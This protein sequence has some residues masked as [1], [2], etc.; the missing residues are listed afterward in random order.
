MKLWANWVHVVYFHSILYTDYF[1]FQLLA[2]PSYMP[3]AW[4]LTVVQFGYLAL[5]LADS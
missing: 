2:S 4:W 3:I 5:R 1:G